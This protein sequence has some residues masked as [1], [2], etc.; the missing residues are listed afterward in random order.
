MVSDRLKSI[1]SLI[2]NGENV[3]DVGCDHALLDIYLTLYKECCCSCYDVNADIINRAISN[4]SK[5]NLL[6]KIKTFVGNGFNN[7]ELPF[8]SI[9]VLS[10][11]G[12]YTILKILDKNKTRDIICQTNTDLYLLRYEICNMGYYI[13]SEDIVFDNNRYYVS[14]RFSYGKSDYTYDEYLLGPCLIKSNSSVFLDYVKYLYKKNI[15]TYDK[16]LIYNNCSIDL[17]KMIKCLEKYLKI[18]L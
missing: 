7:L 14:I 2:E 12:T 13:S 6:D 1:S 16:S 9:M 15:R 18:Q 4:I 11:M 5:Y 17:E 8:D 10:G 3:V